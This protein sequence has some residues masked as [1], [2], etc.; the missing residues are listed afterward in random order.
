VNENNVALP[1]N[2][3][4]IEIEFEIEIEIES[5]SERKQLDPAHKLERN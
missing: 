2:W 5:E 4:E 3:K 1:T